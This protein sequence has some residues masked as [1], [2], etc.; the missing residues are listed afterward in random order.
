MERLHNS[1]RQLNG[2]LVGEIHDYYC[3]RGLRRIYPPF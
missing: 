3:L 2:F 1:I